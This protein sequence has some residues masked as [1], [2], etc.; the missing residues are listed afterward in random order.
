MRPQPQPTV[1]THTRIIDGT[2]GPEY[3]GDIVLE[4]GKI[5]SI[6]P[7][8]SF[9]DHLEN[10]HV[11]DGAGL[12][13]CPGFIDMH[14]G[15]DLQLMKSP[16]CLP[17]ITQGVTTEVLGQD[18]LFYAAL[19]KSSFFPSPKLLEGWKTTLGHSKSSFPSVQDSLNTLD[20]GVGV[21]TVFLMPHS[22][23]RFLTVGEENGGLSESQIAILAKQ[24][25]EALEQGAVG[26]SSGFELSS[27]EYP[28]TRELEA[29]CE[30]IATHGAFYSSGPLSFGSDTTKNYAELLNIASKTSVSLHLT[31]IAPKIPT[32]AVAVGELIQML[33]SSLE[34]GIDLSTD[35]HPYVAN[36][37]PLV[38]LLP[39]WSREGSIDDTLYNIDDEERAKRIQHELK[40]GSSDGCNGVPIDW[41]TITIYSVANTQLR[42]LI[43]QSIAAIARIQRVEPF[44]VFCNILGADSLAT[45]VLHNP[46]NE[47]NLVALMKHRTHTGGS[48]S[49]VESLR[50]HPS[51]FGAFPRFISHYVRDLGV[52]ELPEMIHHLTG[53][54]AARLK[55]AERG[56]IRDGYAADLVIF[57]PDSIMDMSSFSDP[58]EPAAGINYVF[59]NGVLA[60]KDRHPTEALAGR[61]LR[62]TP[63][64]TVQ[65]L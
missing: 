60:L 53:R 59:V 35:I 56:Q 5:T 44:T 46:G 24:V 34:S 22:T 45:V 57:D 12:I 28:E 64:R 48:A 37:I 41:E 31:H 21:N 19:E 36:A 61:A 33:D 11:I 58:Q 30:V 1:I 18:G 8:G 43:N 63:S 40:L 10:T 17:K 65:A 62:R 38:S 16:K 25:E 7:P 15:S 47:E 52:M 23:L 55:L 32:S 54:P 29:L 13:T 4:H 27:G 39:S 9:I 20:E 50:P 51:D 26:I 6:L 2:G 42:V 3:L 49:K 14:G